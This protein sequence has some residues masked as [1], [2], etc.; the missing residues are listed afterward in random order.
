MRI[1]WECRDEKWFYPKNLIWKN[2]IGGCKH[3]VLHPTLL[4]LYIATNV[5]KVHLLIIVYTFCTTSLALLNS[6]SRQFKAIVFFVSSYGRITLASS[7]YLCMWVLREN[8]Y[9]FPA[10]LKYWF[11]FFLQLLGAVLPFVQGFKWTRL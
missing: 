6:Y 2:A 8:F 4:K 5:Y 7:S 11:N 1:V 3:M 10:N 9:S